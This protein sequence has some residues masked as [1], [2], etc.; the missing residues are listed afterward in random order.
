[1]GQPFTETYYVPFHDTRLTVK[2]E[3]VREAAQPSPPRPSPH[4]TAKANEIGGGGEAL[5]SSFGSF[6]SFSRHTQSAAE[7]HATD[8]DESMLLELVLANLCGMFRQISC[9]GCVGP[10]GP[11]KGEGYE[12][13]ALQTLEQRKMSRDNSILGKVVL[14]GDELPRCDGR[15]LFCGGR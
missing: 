13:E 15:V 5:D 2:V 14:C 9:C 6:L 10:Y 8:D 7:P 1:M 12:E 4:E 3:F 11:A